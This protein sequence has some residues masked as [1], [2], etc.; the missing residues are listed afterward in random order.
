[1]VGTNALFMFCEELI[2]SF[3]FVSSNNFYCLVME[4]GYV[5][6]SSDNLPKIHLG[7]MIDDLYISYLDL[8]NSEL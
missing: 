2:Y 6:G 4:Q 7:N 5:M 3:F 8:M 1:M